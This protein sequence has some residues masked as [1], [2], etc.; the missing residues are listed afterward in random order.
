MLPVIPSTCDAVG[1]VRVTF[2]SIDDLGLVDLNLWRFG[3]TVLCL[4]KYMRIAIG[5]QI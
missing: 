1:V 3:Y 2:A 4:L 5:K